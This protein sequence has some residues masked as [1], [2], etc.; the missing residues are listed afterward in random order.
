[1]F[2]VARCKDKFIWCTFHAEIDSRKF[3]HH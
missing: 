3:R 2:I 1:V